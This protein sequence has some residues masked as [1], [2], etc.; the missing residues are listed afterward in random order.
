MTKRTYIK[1]SIVAVLILAFAAVAA[2]QFTGGR[3]FSS[4]IAGL[5]TQFNK[6]KGKVRLVVLLAPT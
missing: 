2:F 4:D 5:K 3:E 6:D 1:I